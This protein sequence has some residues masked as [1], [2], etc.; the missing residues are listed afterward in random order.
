MTQSLLAINYQKRKNA[1]LFNKFETN[2]HL[3]IVQCQ[4]YIPIYNKFFSLNQTNFNGIN[5][6][7]TWY[8]SDIKNHKHNN[9]KDTNKKDKNNDVECLIEEPVFSFLCKLKHISDDDSFTNSQKCFL[10][11]A[12]LLDPFKYIVGKYDDNNPE[13]FTLPCLNKKNIH[14]KIMNPN[15][16]S[17]IDGFFS[18]LS[19]NL[20][21]KHFFING[22]DYYGSFIGIK[23]NYKINVI[24]D[25]DYL[26]E[27]ECFL[28]GANKL[29]TIQ[30]YSHLVVEGETDKKP[31]L[32]FVED[33]EVNSRK[34]VLSIKS[35]DNEVFENL[36]ENS[37]IKQIT[38]DDLK[39]MN[40]EL[41]DITNST[42]F[43]IY[44]NNNNN[45]NN[46]VTDITSNKSLKTSS[47]CSSRTSH[48]NDHEDN[49]LLAELDENQSINNSIGL[50][51]ITNPCQSDEETIW[52]DVSEEESIDDDEKIWLTIP[53]FPVQIICTEEF[54]E[55]FDSLIMDDEYS[56]DECLAAL[57][58][59]IMT[60]ITYQKCF[61]F[62][63]NDLH[64]NNIM[65][66]ETNLKYICYK[67]NKLVY[68]IPTFGK[69]Y[70]IIDFGR[71]IY[72][73]NSKICCSDSFQ[74]GGDAAG[75]YNT[76]P[77]FNEN[78]PRLEPNFSF[79]L[80]RLAC[81]IFDFIVDDF[82]MTKKMDSLTPLQKIITEWCIDD[83][84]INVLYKNNG[85]ERYPDFKLYKMIARHVHNH[86]PLAQLER[87]EF[88]K[89]LV[90]NSPKNLQKDTIIDI[91]SIPSYI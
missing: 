86:T 65:Y 44:T 10:K 37:E 56:E 59:I 1:H 91:D 28:K 49:L 46:N 45:N 53:K 36:F 4:N 64:S 16:S 82:E 31:I 7:H 55:T 2:N 26:I 48:T 51:E 32:T 34:S 63:H 61:S 3:N 47:D 9:K 6:N 11:M 54:E 75:Q 67:F 83:N 35:L 77:Y 81:S 71:A 29:Y 38:L 23:N 25:L 78:K 13:L 40:M 33:I 12:P 69:I 30:D 27:S 57:M 85:L 79:D 18:F 50:E 24:D 74:T 66:T 20:L 21:H 14:D 42:E 70:K 88:K 76:E 8:I 73:V 60:L 39:T 72:K 89:Y 68:K 90:N 84:G 87:P 58:Q 15:N 43:D 17:Y 22:I 41:V 80:C 19:S 52:E 62:T 5:L